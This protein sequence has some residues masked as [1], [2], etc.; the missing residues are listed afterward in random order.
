[1][2]LTCRRAARRFGYAND[3]RDDRERDARRDD[4]HPIRLLPGDDVAQHVRSGK[5]EDERSAEAQRHVRHGRCGARRTRDAACRDI[6]GC[7]EGAVAHAHDGTTRQNDGIDGGGG[8]NGHTH[9]HKREADQQQR[10]RAA[11]GE[12]HDQKRRADGVAHAVDAHHEADLGK[13]DARD[14]RD[15]I[16]HAQDVLVGAPEH[17]AAKRQHQDHEIAASAA[18]RIPRGCRFGAAHA[19]TSCAP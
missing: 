12:R 7:R 13:I 16:G 15:L 1:M 10:F 2:T 6:G 19:L 5:R 11:R 8:A 3:E 14:L 4:E 18:R 17:E 9:R